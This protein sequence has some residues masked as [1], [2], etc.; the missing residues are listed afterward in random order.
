MK[1]EIRWILKLSIAIVMFGTMY[2]LCALWINTWNMYEWPKFLQ[3]DY[4]IA[5][6]FVSFGIFTSPTGADDE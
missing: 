1:R 6:V 4:F 2:G 3:V 5:L